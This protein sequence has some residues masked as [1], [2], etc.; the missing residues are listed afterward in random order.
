[1][2]RTVFRVL[3]LSML[4]L[5]GLLF[6]LWWTYVRAP[7]P[8]QVCERIVAVSLQDAGDRELS[9]DTRA[10]MAEMIGKRCHKLELDRI[11]LRGRLVY[12]EHAKCVMAAGTLAEIN[13]C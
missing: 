3:S 6:G 13:R 5:T 9:V 4:G 11:Q 10:K 8:E 12:A 7:V 1:M 2:S